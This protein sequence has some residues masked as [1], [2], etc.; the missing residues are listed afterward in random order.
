MA[1]L[2][3]IFYTMKNNWNLAY[4]HMEEFSNIMM[5]EKTR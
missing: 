5:S 4:I 1:Y 2:Y 3:E